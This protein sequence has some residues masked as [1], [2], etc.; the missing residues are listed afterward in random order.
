M[1]DA[2][3][4]NVN[5]LDG[6]HVGSGNE[7]K[8][9]S[10]GNERPKVR[11]ENNEDDVDD[12]IEV[13]DDEDD[14]HMNDDDLIENEDDVMDMEIDSDLVGE[15]HKPSFGSIQDVVE[16]DAIVENIIVDEGGP[17]EVDEDVVGLLPHFSMREGRK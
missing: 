7:Q 5:L 16:D 17:F 8:T 12:N 11:N 6:G 9:D 15:E 1:N 14:E 2:G 3:F 13:D 10:N 4:I